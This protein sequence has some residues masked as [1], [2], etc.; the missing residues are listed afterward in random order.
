MLISQGS[1]FKAAMIVTEPSF[2][3]HT[4]RPEPLAGRT[5]LQIIPSLDTG[6]AERTTLDIAAALAAVGARPLVATEGGRLVAELQARGGIWIPFPASRK[7]PLAIWRNAGAIAKLIVHEG[8]DLVHA[9]SRAPAWSARIATQRGKVPFVTTYHGA[10][11]AHSSWKKRYNSVMAM[12]DVVIANSRY[13][14]RLIA[15]SWPEAADRVAVI[16]RGTD[17][18]VFSVASVPVDRVDA[19]RR[20]WGSRLI[21]ALFCCRGGLRRGKG[22]GC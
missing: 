5:V 4:D 15:Q 18:A 10:Y 21:G 17:L 8:V 1:K 6:G 12:G 13:T 14:A 19:L 16:Y 7:N 22:K 3:N 9:R 20:A 2:S 11:A